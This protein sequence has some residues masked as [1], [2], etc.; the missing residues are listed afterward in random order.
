MPRGAPSPSLPCTGNYVQRERSRYAQPPARQPQPVQRARGLPVPHP[1]ARSGP[2][3]GLHP[4][5]KQGLSPPGPTGGTSAP[6]LPGLPNSQSRGQQMGPRQRSVPGEQWGRCGRGPP[7]RPGVWPLLWERAR[8]ARPRS[9][10]PA[11][12]RRGRPS[13]ESCGGRS[14]AERSG[15]RGELIPGAE[16]SRAARRVSRRPPPRQLSWVSCG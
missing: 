15:W 9:A 6:K 13:R 5:T 16:R 2:R 14:G 3:G 1:S 8:A 4:R 12:G 11:R 7:A 10:S